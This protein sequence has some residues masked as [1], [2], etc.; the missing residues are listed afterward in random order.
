M[1]AGAV[2]LPLLLLL[3]KRMALVME[4]LTACDRQLNLGVLA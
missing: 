3:L 1:P 2:H 4:L